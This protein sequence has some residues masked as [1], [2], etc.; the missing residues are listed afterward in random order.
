V[1]LDKS[2]KLVVQSA[3]VIGW[4]PARPLG[5]QNPPGA[6]P[7]PA[8]AP[9]GFGGI[10]LVK[11]GTIGS[12][13]F[14]LNDVQV[15]DTA[16]KKVDK[17]DLAKLLKEETVAMASLGGREIDP[18]HLRVLKEGTLVFILPMPNAGA[19]PPGIRLL[20]G[21]VIPVPP[22]AVPLPGPAAPP[23]PPG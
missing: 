6:L 3:T 2:G 4:I 16:G 12:H 11:P 13:T 23:V 22:K 17:K 14:D 21:G 9:G 8:P 5:I 15:L 20:P 7:A 18:L 19:V 1:S 10:G